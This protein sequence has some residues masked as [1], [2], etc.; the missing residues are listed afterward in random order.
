MGFESATTRF[1]ALHYITCMR[2]C[3]G[4][5]GGG[6]LKADTLVHVHTHNTC[7]N[8]TSQYM[9]SGKLCTVGKCKCTVI[10]P[11]T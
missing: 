6:T 8:Y 1:I 9:H 3:G 5:R 7:C 2:V 4:G 11:I 10:M